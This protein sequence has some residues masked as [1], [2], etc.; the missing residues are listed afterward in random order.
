MHGAGAILRTWLLRASTRQRVLVAVV[1][2]IVGAVLAA[3]GDVRAGIIGIAGLL[4]LWGAVR[5]GRRRSASR[6][7]L[8]NGAGPPGEERS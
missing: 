8:D 6:S 5:N 1:L 3:L 2:V 4:I 7:R